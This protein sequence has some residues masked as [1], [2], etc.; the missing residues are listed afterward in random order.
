MVSNLNNPLVSIIVATYNSSAT[1]IETLDSIYDQTYKNIE[2]IVTDDNSKDNT[3]EIVDEWIKL[4]RNRFVDSSLLRSSFNTG[5]SENFNR[6]IRRSSGI[7]IKPFGGDDILF[8]NYVERLLQESGDADM[9]ISRLYLFSGNKE[10]INE[11]VN[12]SFVNYLSK[13]QLVMIYARF[14][15]FFNIPTLLIRSDVYEKVGLYDS[16]SPY[17]ED[18]PFIMAFFKAGLCAKFIDEPLVWYRKGGMSNEYN[19]EKAK[20]NNKKL[21]DVC[22]TFLYCN[23]SYTNPIDLIVRIDHIIFKTVLNSNSVCIYKLFFSRYNVF[24][25]LLKYIYKK[26]IRQN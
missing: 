6:G 21:A 12:L 9:I 16:R 11:G 13:R 19:I 23:L 25:Q 22:D 17:F 3:C 7:W 14:H 15:P 26:S 5:V 10:I 4:H 18:M 1:I 8:P 24:R 2:L 20:S